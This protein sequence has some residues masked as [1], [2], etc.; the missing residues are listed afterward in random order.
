MQVVLYSWQIIFSFVSCYIFE[1]CFRLGYAVCV[2]ELNDGVLHW[3]IKGFNAGHFFFLSDVTMSTGVISLKYIMVDTKQNWEN[4]W[5]KRRRKR[6]TAHGGL[7]FIFQTNFRKKI[8]ELKRMQSVNLQW[9]LQIYS[10]YFSYYCFGYFHLQNLLNTV[11]NT[12]KTNNQQSKLFMLH[13]RRF[14]RK[15]KY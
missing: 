9:F 2:V 8:L 5:Q 13:F 15:W 6:E 11:E 1:S 12:G 7:L 3:C 4:P 10:F 14:T